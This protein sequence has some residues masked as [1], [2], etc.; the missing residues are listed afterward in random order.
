MSYDGGIR[1]FPFEESYQR[2]KRHL[3]FRC[4]GV[5]RRAVV[6][7]EPSDVADADGVGVMP[8]AVRSYLCNVATCGHR[9]IA[10]DDVVIPDSLEAPLFVPSSDVLHGEVLSFGSCRAMDDNLVYFSHDFRFSLTQRFMLLDMSDM[11]VVVK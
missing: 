9:P 2:Q 10:V 3:L 1:K 8:F 5:L 4:S 7:G 11:N 6:G